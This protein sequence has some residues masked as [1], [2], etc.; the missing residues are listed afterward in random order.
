MNRESIWDR[1]LII[2]FMGALA[3]LFDSTSASELP[4]IDKRIRQLEKVTGCKF[5]VSSGN[6]S[7]ARNKRV[8]GAKNSYHLKKDQ[9][10]DI[11]KVS[12]RSC[13]L[14][15]AQLARLARLTF[16]GVIYYKKHLHLDLR[17][18]KSYFAKG[19]YKK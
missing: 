14:S 6:R 11:T 4:E 17:S 12:R 3:A 19:Y 7:K 10:R 16:P 9:A 15:Y 18:G 13:S 5:K 1:I 8:G 2:A